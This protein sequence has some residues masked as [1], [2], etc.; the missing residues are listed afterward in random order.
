MTRLGRYVTTQPPGLHFKLPFG[1]DQVSKVETTVV[2]EES[3]GVFQA[4]SASATE[5]MRQRSPFG[6]SSSGRADFSRNLKEESLMLTGDLNV[7]DVEWVVQYRIADPRQYLFNVADPIKNMRD[8]AQAA[9]RRVVGDRT[10]N[11]VLTTGRSQIG[12]DVKI[13]MQQIFSDYEMGVEILGVK[14]QDVNPPEEVKPSFNAVN[15]ARQIQRQ[16]INTA[17]A[18]YNKVIPKALGEKEQLIEQARGYKEARVNR[19]RGDADRFKKVLL[20][21][22][23][24]P[25][26]TRTRI[27]LELTEE[28]V[29]RV[30]ALT[31][32]DPDI[33]GVLPVFGSLTAPDAQPQIK[34]SLRPDF[35]AANGDPKQ[36]QEPENQMEMLNQSRRN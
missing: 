11:D 6:L 33:Q 27:Y 14:L 9:M 26:L 22:K 21:Y 36:A 32:I 13:I 2:L 16:L 20:E 25:E 10:V 15:A 5:S 1:I 4:S 3:F 28:L 12:D 24:A 17:E 19:A 18:E 31:I 23:K 35:P 8:I 34:A 29:S 7:A 30:T